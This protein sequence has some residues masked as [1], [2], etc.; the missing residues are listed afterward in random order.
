[1]RE[2]E[3]KRGEAREEEEGDRIFSLYTSMRERVMSVWYSSAL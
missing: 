1:V 2:D 3:E